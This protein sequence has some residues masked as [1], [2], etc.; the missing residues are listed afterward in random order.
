[1]SDLRMLLA[2]APSTFQAIISFVYPKIL[3]T[4]AYAVKL[5]VWRLKGCVVLKRHMLT[6]CSWRRLLCREAMC[7]APHWS[8]I[9]SN[10]M[11]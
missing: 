9:A 2:V 7:I 6:Q 3:K 1:M 5:Q 10:R 4:T 11:G 8:L